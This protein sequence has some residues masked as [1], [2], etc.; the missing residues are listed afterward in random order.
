MSVAP[1][2]KI[3]RAKAPERRKQ[4]RKG[5]LWHGELKTPAGSMPCRVLNLS[6]RGAKLEVDG[7]ISAGE[8]V[9]LVM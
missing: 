6:V 3:R 5:T 1:S 9:A 4:P 2:L 8:I 7:R